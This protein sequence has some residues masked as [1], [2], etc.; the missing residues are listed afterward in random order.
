MTNYYATAFR[1]GTY[2]PITEDQIYMWARPHPKDAIAWN[3]TV[4][5][6][7]SYEL[8]CL[9]DSSTVHS[10]SY[11]TRYIDGGQIVGRRLRTGTGHRGDHD[12]T[13]GLADGSCRTRCDQAVCGPG[14]GFWYV[15][16]HDTPGG[17][18]GPC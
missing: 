3:D 11:R 8:V 15:C 9:S 16:D 13:L 1:T 5:K 7:T 4:G 17:D 6:P 14:T 12:G 10:D 2:P 18:S